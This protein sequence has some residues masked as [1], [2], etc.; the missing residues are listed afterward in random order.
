M[1]VAVRLNGKRLKDQHS[2]EIRE[3][4]TPL[5][6]NDSSGAVGTIDLVVS[7]QP[8]CRLLLNKPITFSDTRLGSTLGT[9]R[10][11]GH[12]NGV[13]TISANNRLGD[14]IIEVQVQPF[15]GTLEQAFR[16]Y[17]S[18]AGMAE[19]IVVD[20]SIAA[21]PVTFQGWYGNLWLGI[22]QMALAMDCDVSLISDNV[23]LRPIRKF[24]AAGGR[25]VDRDS[26]ANSD[27][28]ALKQ[29]VIWYTN[30]YRSNYAVYPPNGL[31]QEE[32]P[33]SADAGET[34]ERDIPLS[35]SVTSIVQPI[36]ST[37]ANFDPFD[38]TESRYCIVGDDNIHVTPAQWAAFGGSVS[39]SIN[40]DTESLTVK[41]VAPSGMYQINGEPMRTFRLG[42]SADDGVYPALTILGD[43]VHFTPNSLVL[44]TNIAP[45]LTSQEFAPTIDNRFLNNLNDAYR[46]GT[47][48]VRKYTGRTMSLS[49]EVTAI[50]R[51]G[52]TGGA[53]Y[54]PYSFVQGLHDSS[55]YGDVADQYAGM[56]YSGV[57]ADLYAL[58]EDDF[59]NQA[60]GNAAGARVFDRETRRFYR[61]REATFSNRA[62]INFSADD[63]LTNGDIQ[64]HFSGMSYGDVS[65]LTRFGSMDYRD[66]NLLGMP[67]VALMGGGYGLGPYGLSPYG[68]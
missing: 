59:E 16:Y 41:I 66:A 32:N 61:I 47:R 64:T 39:V 27:Q 19:G 33:L 63:D 55:T 20:E 67:D 40:E 58:V 60:F 18:L 8:E 62:S 35:A 31:W 51:R 56:S 34:T 44:Q 14:L 1:G 24:L 29:E 36:M 48:A 68:L 46:S 3:S 43:G 12:K 65:T 53:T 37:P 4:S 7:H 17:L 54:P 15:T 50:N 30:E 21:R 6:A 10:S 13:D 57:K 26:I 22:K 52:E 11:V 9:M 25:S 5:A 28:L 49:G 38:M 45:W 42:L 2:Y 23:V